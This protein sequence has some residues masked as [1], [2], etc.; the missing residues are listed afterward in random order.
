[1]NSGFSC[2]DDSSRV[3]CTGTAACSFLTS[4]ATTQVRRHREEVIMVPIARSVVVDVL[5]SVLA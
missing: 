3:M 2:I 1:M 5:L 4:R